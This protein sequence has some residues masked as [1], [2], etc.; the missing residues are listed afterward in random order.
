MLALWQAC[1][2]CGCGMRAWM[3]AHECSVRRCGT[4]GSCRPR[5]L[6]SVAVPSSLPCCVGVAGESS[7]VAGAVGRGCSRKQLVSLAWKH[8]SGSRQKTVQP[9]GC[10]CMHVCVHVCMRL[11]RR[12]RRGE[13]VSRT[14][15]SGL[16]SVLIHATNSSISIS[17]PPSMSTLPNTCFNSVSDTSRLATLASRRMADRNS[18]KSREPLLSRS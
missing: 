17:P 9:A 15:S 16:S 13:G 18:S 2:A 11:T 12:R 4:S 3:A 7:P 10:V 6:S 5:T 8:G 14:M 1:C